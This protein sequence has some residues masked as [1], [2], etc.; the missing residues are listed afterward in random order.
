ME[1]LLTLVCVVLLG[2][3][4][5]AGYLERRRMVQEGIMVRGIVT[6]YDDGQQLYHI[7][8]TFR[9]GGHRVHG[10]AAIHR[11]LQTG[12]SVWVRYLPSDPSVNEPLGAVQ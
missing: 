1:W 10:A 9:A 6:D 5:L 7:D 4:L 3:A 2:Y 12:D 8:Y 11:P